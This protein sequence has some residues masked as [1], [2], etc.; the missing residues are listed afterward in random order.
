MVNI[1]QKAKTFLKHHFPAI[2]LLLLTV[3]SADSAVWTTRRHA[4]SKSFTDN[5]LQLVSCKYIVVLKRNDRLKASHNEVQK[6]R[7]F[8]KYVE[9]LSACSLGSV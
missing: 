5:H 3:L 6:V 1:M 7:S 9:V 8:V 2:Q 4:A